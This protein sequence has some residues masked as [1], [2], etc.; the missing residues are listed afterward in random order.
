MI[1]LRVLCTGDHTSEYKK[2]VLVSLTLDC[3]ELI[4]HHSTATAAD[5]EDAAPSSSVDVELTSRD[6]QVRRSQ[7]QQLACQHEVLST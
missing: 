7:R 4:N 3:S 2:R 1:V 5:E 6:T